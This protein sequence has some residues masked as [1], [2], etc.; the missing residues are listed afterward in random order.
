MLAVLALLA[1]PPAQ[2][3]VKGEAVEYKAGDTVFKGYLAYDDAVKGRR[4]GVLVVHEW[5][6]HNEYAR[7]RARMLAELGYTALAVDM[8]GDGKQAAH[9]QDAGKFS[10]EVRK[11]L[12]LAK[13]RFDAARQLL[14]K[15]PT[16]N[17]GQ[18][19]A[20]GYCFGG[21]IVLEMARLGENLK[22]VVSFHG[23]LN[24]EQPAKP[25]KFKAQALVLTGADD[26]FIP[27]EQ[28]EAFKKEMDAAKVKYQVVVYPGAR[29]SFTAREADE[30][31]Q[32][33]N[34]PALAY[35]AEADRKS[36]AEMQEFLKKVLAKR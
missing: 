7:M 14:V 27:A 8:Y 6:G 2:A 36:W 18:I 11:N 9:P 3:A 16:V 31:S 20:V 4:P 29:H 19:A 22:G 33:F 17:S 21:A 10:G 15:H 35:N 30:N 32:K 25:G 34:L 26:P 24:T 13:V 23:N 12:P 28:V 5:W 1:V